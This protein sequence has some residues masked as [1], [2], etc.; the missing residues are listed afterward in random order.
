M[1]LV[2]KQVVTHCCSFSVI[3]A[4]ITITTKL[5]INTESINKKLYFNYSQLLTVLLS[6]NS[7]SS[8]S[9][10]W[11]SSLES[12]RSVIADRLPSDERSKP[13]V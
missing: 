10:D 2:I 11:A 3:I 6:A 1:V 8:F 5:K 7:V 9:I 12:P 13:V 4:I